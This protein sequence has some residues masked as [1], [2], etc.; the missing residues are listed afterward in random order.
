M[1]KLNTGI[2]VNCHGRTGKTGDKRKQL[3]RNKTINKHQWFTVIL[4]A[5]FMNKKM[6]SQI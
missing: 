1:I 6:L 3:S 4:K 2:F 5:Q